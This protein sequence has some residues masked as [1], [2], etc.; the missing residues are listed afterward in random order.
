MKKCE[1]VNLLDF[2][3]IF[4][5]HNL[6]CLQYMEELMAPILFSWVASGVNLAA[7]LEVVCFFFLIRLIIN[8]LLHPK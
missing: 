8:N 1:I 5:W 3:N 6:V 2:L 4:L 7:L